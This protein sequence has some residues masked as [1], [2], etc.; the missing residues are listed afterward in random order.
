[1]L[2]NRKDVAGGIAALREM[3][4]GGKLQ[5]KRIPIEVRFLGDALYLNDDALQLYRSLGGA[6]PVDAIM[7][8]LPVH[9]LMGSLIH[10]EW[11]EER[12]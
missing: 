3:G 4:F 10:D 2:Q 12:P 8:S 9:T 11:Y 5:A 6:Q 1:M 7:E